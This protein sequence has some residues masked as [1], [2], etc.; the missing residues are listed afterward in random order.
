M[1]PLL[2]VRLIEE[3][4]VETSDEQKRL[5]ETLFGDCLNLYFQFLDRKYPELTKRFFSNEEMRKHKSHMSMATKK[6]ESSAIF[7]QF[8][9]KVFDY[10]RLSHYSKA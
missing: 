2:S 9:K 7:G 8:Y 10:L 1:L 5:K 3:I 6:D 4:E